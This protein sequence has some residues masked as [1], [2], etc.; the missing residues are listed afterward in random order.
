MGCEVNWPTQ[1]K[2]TLKITTDCI[3]SNRMNLKVWKV[4]I[5]DQWLKTIMITVQPEDFNVGINIKLLTDNAK[6]K[7]YIPL[8]TGF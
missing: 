5:I 6:V 4:T 3:I 8:N 1:E 7:T 2:V